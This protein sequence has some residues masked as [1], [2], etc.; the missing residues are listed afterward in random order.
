MDIIPSVEMDIIYS[1][2]PGTKISEGLILA[3]SE[4]F[5]LHYGIWS[6]LGP[7]PGK[8]VSMNVTKIKE[9]CIFDLKSCGVVIAE[10]DNV[11]IGHA[12]YHKYLDPILGKVAWITQ[13]V[14]NS[15]VR[16][17][18]IA[19]NLIN[20]LVDPDTNVCGMVTSHPYAIRSLEKGTG[21]KVI[22]FVISAIVP[23]IINNL[24]IPYINNSLYH[25]HNNRGCLLNTKFYV[26]HT[27][28]LKIIEEQKEIGNWLLEDLPD[29]YEYIVLIKK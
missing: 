2:I 7:R 18:G 24:K 29:G 8:N 6:L 1:L 13:L 15:N 28:I 20:I 25:C 17:K 22:P 14:V 9:N 23:L 12:F 3:C 16:N 19:K 27:D 11:L 10:L 5:S 4:L 26:D 21:Y